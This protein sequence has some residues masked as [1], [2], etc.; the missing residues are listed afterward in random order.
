M[1]ALT[2][3]DLPVGQP[4]PWSLLDETGNLMLGSGNVIN[5][6]RDVALIFRQGSVFRHGDDALPGDRPEGKAAKGPLGLQIGTLLQVKTP[7]DNSRAAASRL[8]GFVEQGLFISWPQLGGK[9]LPVAAGENVVLRGFSGEAIY[10]FTCEVTAVCR[11]PFRYLVL[12]A[13]DQVE[14]LPV[15]KAARVPTRLAGQ[16]YGPA[17]NAEL[18]GRLVVLS[19]LST[20]G[21]LIEMAGSAPPSGTQL[22]LKFI[23][24]TAAVADTEITVD[25]W[26]RKPAPDRA[27]NDFCTFGASFDVLP[28][29]ELALLQ[30]YIYEHLLASASMRV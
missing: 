5:D 1:I 20:G 10:S 18:P 14:P 28:D 21:A 9:D 16:L 22:K 30:C 8:M 11:S 27:D 12:S 4:L 7:G 3:N 19:D 6:G 26:A 25:A 24:Q 17:D 29:Y 2:P 13:P 23:L 15:R